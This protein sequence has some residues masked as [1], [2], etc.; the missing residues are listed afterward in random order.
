MRVDYGDG[1]TDWIYVGP[2]GFSH[3]AWQPGQN[4]GSVPFN[5]GPA[6]KLSGTEADVASGI[7][8]AVTRGA[9]VINLS[10]AG[11]G[12]TGPIEEALAYARSAGVLV[13]AAAGNASTSNDEDP[14]YPASSTLDNVVA[15]AATDSA[16]N[17][18][19]FSNYGVASVDV[20]AP[21]VAI[22]STVLGSNFALSSG[23]SMATP[24]VAGLAALIKSVNSS[25]SYFDMRTIILGTTDL[26]P[27]LNGKIGTGGRVN[28][29]QALLVAQGATPIPTPPP[30]VTPVVEPGTPAEGNQ[31]SIRSRRLT[32][33]I[34]IYG[35]IKDAQGGSVA[36]SKVHLFCTNVTRQRIR[37]DNDG[38]YAFKISRPRQKTRCYVQDPENNRSRKHRVI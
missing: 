24:Y 10:L 11:S 1:W 27:D 8:Y 4:R 17:L 37:S 21:G 18:A 9:S 7:R 16:D 31:L 14:T 2:E 23:T 22:L 28:A 26:V 6:V 12:V 32:H 35:Y 34:L 29:E 5:F 19:W 13:V 36:D 15:V 3:A 33:K 38:Y 20:G 25:L 30:E